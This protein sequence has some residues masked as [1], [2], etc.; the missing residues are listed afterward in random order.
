MKQSFQ[1]IMSPTYGIAKY[2]GLARLRLNAAVCRC[3]RPVLVYTMGKVGTTTL[4]QSLEKSLAG[5]PIYHLHTLDA[6]RIRQ[7]EA[8]SRRLFCHSRTVHRHLLN[9]LFVQHQVMRA[10]QPRWKLI[11][12]VRE[13]VA[14]NVSA[15]F[16]M[17]DKEYRDQGFRRRILAGA[18][19]G[20]LEEMIRFFHETWVHGNALHWFDRE[21]KRV[22]GV[23]VLAG[24]FPH[25]K[26]YRIVTASQCDVLVMRLEDLDRCVGPAVKA[27]LGVE[28]NPSDRGQH[29][30]RKYYAD[31]YRQFCRKLVLPGE[32]LD[33]IYGSRMVRHFYSDQEIAAFRSKWEPATGGKTND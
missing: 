15:F 12:M 5:T 1:K 25:T 21:I 8:L 11:T 3:H 24:E 26:G 2:Q 16:Q 33:E 17:L 29:S 23:D 28:L 18:D 9:S 31:T 20:L 14:R 13:P 7:M 19:D 32:V 22:F 30:A 27:Y 6:E 4:V 10:G